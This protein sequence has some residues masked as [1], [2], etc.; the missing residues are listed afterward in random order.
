MSIDSC[1]RHF[2]VVRERLPIERGRWG[3]VLVDPV[4]GFV[5]PGAGA[6]APREES[7][8]MR[9][10]VDVCDQ[11]ARAF[12]KR[13][14]PVFVFLDCHRPDQ[15]EPP[16]PPHCVRGSG[17]EEIVAE[18][19]WLRNEPG[20]SFRNKDCVNGFVGAVDTDGRNVFSEWLKT[21]RVENLLVAGI[22]TDICVMDL[23]LTVLSARNHG[24]LSGLQEV[25]VDADGCTTY[26]LPMALTKEL[27]LPP[28]A[29]HLRCESH[30]V[31][32]YFM[33]S[34]GARIAGEVVFPDAR[35]L[36]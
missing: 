4:K 34:R 6:L 14:R 2:P 13:K 27:G 11:R 21:H 26:D 32:L 8:S 23:V 25:F 1:A 7:P 28:S 3:L 9:H 36:V 30:H 33:A 17:E 15:K 18:L 35:A 24:L 22:C 10:M 20:V 12:L 31:G 16:Y 19:E 5:C 29:V